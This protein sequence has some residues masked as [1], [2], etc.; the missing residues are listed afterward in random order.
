MAVCELI[1]TD[2]DKLEVELERMLPYFGR[3]RASKL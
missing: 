1:A 2:Y 3:L